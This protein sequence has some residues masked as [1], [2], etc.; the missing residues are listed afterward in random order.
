M[1]VHQL[2]VNTLPSQA[3]IE[4]RRYMEHVIA[5]NFTRLDGST[6]LYVARGYIM[7]GMAA[8]AIPH[9]APFRPQLDLSMMAVIEVGY[10]LMLLDR[11]FI[12]ITY[13]FA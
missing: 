13:N 1:Y 9:D 10:S 8:W 4:G 3:A 12:V 7:S 5:E 11:E 2:I 6:D